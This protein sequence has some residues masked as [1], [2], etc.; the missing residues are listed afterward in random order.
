[1]FILSVLFVLSPQ[2]GPSV[3]V[4][5]IP[6]SQAKEATPIFD[7]KRALKKALKELPGA[8]VSV[9]DVMVR[10]GKQEGAAVWFKP[11]L[12]QGLFR[13]YAEDWTPPAAYSPV[14]LP[15]WMEASAQRHGGNLPR[16]Y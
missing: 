12:K 6:Q 5:K 10:F 9:E 15:A 14:A 11:L 16:S 7:Q 8:V 3:P 4:G 2:V 1:M 13:W